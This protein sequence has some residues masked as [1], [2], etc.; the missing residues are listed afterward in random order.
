MLKSGVAD[1]FLR[2]GIGVA[3]GLVFGWLLSNVST[4]FINENPVGDREPQTIELVI[5]YG[6]ADQISQGA[7]VREI[8]SDITFVQG[9]LLVVKNEDKVP[10][11]LGPLFVP[12]KTSSVLN[13]DKPNTYSYECTF[14]PTKFIGL[15]VLPRIT[16][17]TRLQAIMAIGLP[18]GMMIGL[19]SYMY[20]GRKKKE[21]G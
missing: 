15:T 16:G 14:E 17:E 3:V 6:T 18:T 4:F 20:T 8:P 12:S 9:D 7:A 11:Q 5:P 13:L 19:Y 10:H 21:E 1:F 2:M